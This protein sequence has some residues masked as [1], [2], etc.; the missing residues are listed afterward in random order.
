MTHGSEEA[1]IHEA[2]KRGIRGRAL[3][4][5]G[6]GDEDAA[7]EDG[8]ATGEEADGA[9]AARATRKARRA[10]TARTD[11]AAGTAAPGAEGDAADPAGAAHDPDAAAGMAA[12]PDPDVPADGGAARARV[13]G[14]EG[15]A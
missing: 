14:G 1:L 5:I 3:R 2:A 8:E 10:R 4:L 15:E 7:P 6:Y 13:P 11:G 9:L 12:T